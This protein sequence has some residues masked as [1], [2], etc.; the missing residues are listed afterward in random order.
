MESHAASMENLLSGE[1]VPRS[2]RTLACKSNSTRSNASSDW[3]VI[4]ELNIHSKKWTL[5]FKLLYPL[6]HT[7]CFNGICSAEYSHIKSE[8]LAQIHTTIAERQG[9]IQEY[10]L[11]GAIWWARAYNGGLGA[12]PPAGSRGRA[13]KL[14]AFWCCYMSEM[15]LNCYVYELFYGH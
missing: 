7:N 6:N 3:F 15:A 13:P 14:N 4:R 10:R 11:E 2:T 9:R 5:K 1:V 12:V 8:S